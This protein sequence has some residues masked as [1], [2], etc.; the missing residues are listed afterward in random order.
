M[1]GYDTEILSALGVFISIY[2]M[3]LIIRILADFML[4]LI[5][6]IAAVVAFNIS[7]YYDEFRELLSSLRVLEVVG[8]ELAAQATIMDIAIIAGF[9]VLAA[10]IL[11]LP[12]LPFSQTYRLML[13]I[14]K[15][16]SREEDK[17]RQWVIDETDEQFQ[18]Q[19]I[20]LEKFV[21]AELRRQLDNS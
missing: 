17:I 2:L 12:F 5:A 18:L 20:Q 4:A 13:G 10:V 7:T 3:F 21:Q 11:S 9:I 1:T 19:Q 14:E 16:S 15:L 8:I 6:S